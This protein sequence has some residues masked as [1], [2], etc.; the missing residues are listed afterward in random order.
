VAAFL[1]DTGF[2]KAPSLSRLL[3]HKQK[4]LEEKKALEG[5]LE[6]LELEMLRIQQGIFH[7]K[8][9]AILLLEGFD[10][11]GKGG[12]IRTITGHLDPRGVA[13]H[14]VGPPTKEEQ[15]RHW[16][17][18]F[19]RDLPEPGTIALFDRTWYGRVLVEKVEGLAKPARIHDAYREINEFERT[20]ADDGVKILKFFLGVSRDQQLK[21]FEERLDDPYK[22]W[23]LSE[24]DIRNRS[25]WNKYVKAT[26]KMF[27]N[28]NTRQIPW[29]LVPADHKAAARVEV[30]ERIVKEL[31]HWG[32]WIEKQATNMGH[33]TLQQELGKRKMQ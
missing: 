9:R 31:G 23:K 32:S 3:R 5:R 28:T 22:Q 13:V 19:W 27:E 29:H 1:A 24:H 14:A 12:C 21:R 6:K 20:L 4:S 10:A 2:M 15:G 17:Y 33:R 18:R 7:G 16:L 11:A 26:D 25:N 8:G 30:L